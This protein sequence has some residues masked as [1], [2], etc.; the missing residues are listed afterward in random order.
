M[1]KHIYKGLGPPAFPPRQVGHHFVDTLN[2]RN[3]LSV[4]T[5]VPA[6]WQ[7]VV[8]NLININ[9]LMVVPSIFLSTGS[10]GTAPNWTNNG[11]DTH[12]LNIPQ[13][14]TSGVS[15]GL[16]SNA[17]WTSFNSRLYP[18]KNVKFVVKNTILGP[19][20]FNSV[21]AAVDSITDAS[22]SNPY[23]VFVAPGIYTENAITMQ[24]YV[25]VHGLAHDEIV[26]QASSASQHVIIAC[27]NSGISN[28]LLTGATA[29]GFAA[30]YYASTTGTTNTSFFIENCR[31]GTNDS[32][33]IA[34]GTTAATALFMENCKFGGIYPFNHGF[35]GVS[36]GRVILRN[37]TTTGLSAPLPDF[38]FKA[39]GP[40]SQVVL[41][42]VQ[43]RSG[44]LTTGAC[45]HLAD[46]AVCRASSVNIRMFGKAMWLENVGA[47]P[48]MDA[49]A[50]LCEQNTMDIQCDH[51]GADGTITGSMDHNKVFVNTS[52]SLSPDFT[53][54]ASPGDGTGHVTIGSILQGDRFD[55]YLNLSKLI[56]DSATL[57]ADVDPTY[58]FITILSGL[59]V[60]VLAGNGFLN[61][62]TDFFVKEINWPQTDILLPTNSTRYVYA[63]TNGT[64]Q[65]AASLPS[66]KTVIP[67]GRVNTNSTGIRFI[68]DTDLPM[69]HYSNEV[70]YFFRSGLGPVFGSGAIIVENATPR[71][72]DATAGSYFYG[73][74]V[75][76]LTGGTA[77]QWEAFYK[78]GSGGF[79]SITGQDTVSNTNYDDGSGTLAAIP[80]LSYAKHTL[81]A[82][83]DSGNEKW[84]LEYG[85]ATFLTLA[86]A[87][88]APLPTVPSFLSDAVVRIAEIIVQQGTAN[89]QFI[90]DIRPR[91]GFAA[92]SGTAVTD[93]GGL[94]GLLDD[95]HP[96]YLLV[97]GTRAMTGPLNMGTNN[98]TNVGTVNGVTVEAHASRH[99]P[100][101]A[102]PLATAAPLTSLSAITTNAVGIANSL[103]RSDHGHAILTGIAITLLPDQANAAGTS[104]N[105]SRADHIHNVPTDVAIE[106]TDTTN[107]QGVGAAFSRND[108]GHAHGN[109]GGGSLHAL[110]TTVLAGFMSAPDKVKLDGIE[111]GATNTP[112]SNTPPV[113][114]SKSAALVGIATTVARS[115]H[116][117]DIDTA[118]ALSI[119]TANAEGTG[120]SLARA[121]HVHQGV[122]SFNANAGTQRFGDLSLNNGTGI[123]VTDGGTGNFSIAFATVA[124]NSIIANISGGVAA[125]S[126]N[127]LT[128]ILD[129][130]LGTT[131]GSVIYRSGTI[132][133]TLSPGT[134]GQVLTTGGPAANPSWTTNGSGT[135]TS[136]ALTMPSIFSVAGSPVTSAGTLA[137]TLATE[138]ANSVFAGPTSGGAATPT[139]RAL[140]TADLPAGTGTVTSV[141]LASPAEFTV[142]GSPVTTTGT[143][144]LTKATQTANTHWSGPTTGGAAQP[145]FRALVTADLPAGTGTVTSVATGTGL[146]GGTITTTGTISLATIANNSFLANIGGGVAAPTP[147][148]LTAYLDSV[149]GTT[150]GSIIYRNATVWTTLSPGTAGQFLQ[151]AG[152]A[153]NP[154]WASG[155]SGTVTSV[156]LS[157]PSIFTVSG[158]PV[159]TTGTLTGT[160]ATQTAN[161]VFAGPASGG[162]AAPTFRS[163]VIA[164]LPLGTPVTIG[165]ANAAG[166]AITTVRSDH[167][168][169]HGA[170]T[171]GTLHAVVTTSVNGFMSATDKTKLD[172]I[173]IKEYVLYADQME[174]PNNADWALN[175]LASIVADSANAAMRVARFDDTT[176]EGVGFSVL[177]PT[178]ATNVTISIMW[179]GQTSSAGAAGTRQIVPSFYFRQFPNN[180]AI[181]AWSAR[182]TMTTLTAPLS[183][184]AWQYSSQTFSL[185]TLGITA[186]NRDAQFELTRFASSGSDTKTGDWTV[187]RVVLDFT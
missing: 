31:F 169:A 40:G 93:H 100:T 110:V 153:A 22:S 147:T 63:D 49:N 118:I 175:S 30:V 114:V 164:D 11:T 21:K 26:I 3:Y 39:T 15:A 52:S 66:L 172:A 96:Q 150:Q 2:E 107:S 58:S 140:V 9:G 92:P 111:A 29:A 131:Q 117:H 37:C 74:T 142:S 141:A 19:Q 28:C 156:A 151:T 45:I 71:K 32:L 138:V 163:I 67:L 180:A 47:A 35:L 78:D 43:C 159:T 90:N 120:T 95:D 42:G 98:I 176:E 80:A 38:V 115:D 41:N 25:W 20:D 181:T 82:L 61:D 27:D 130:I 12:Y 182:Q 64:V 139:F 89:V 173:S 7:L 16:I 69:N 121:D 46:G 125:P 24:P 146:T 103:S 75:L 137:V 50:I 85:Q 4:G 128:A 56:R 23:V 113:N 79:N 179:R 152:A 108:H 133:T 84:F 5:A 145:T 106:I 170:Q 155:N 143:L 91:I 86:A 54:N 18:W 184:L 77:I 109:R 154:L 1:A 99:L 17:E 76:S 53:S 112:L 185:A 48:I 62:P 83:G 129:S 132:W 127:T 81:Y 87:Q 165:T 174:T 13:A 158:S 60:R 104:A 70:E 183:S 57:G 134:N 34:D 186:D 33:T 105:L 187:R 14:S 177:V 144:T 167:V 124:N 178:G 116:K 102:D 162:A 171:D 68:E 6:D 136:V 51:P 119:G 101:G 157:L 126:A 168:H 97:N 36:G 72:L 55:R 10:A 166:T 148:T 122:H 8:A 135:V 160:L 88:A 161:T 44:S 73:V 149:L 94:T 59:T 65:V 123:T